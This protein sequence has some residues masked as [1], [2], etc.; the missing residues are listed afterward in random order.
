MMTIPQLEFNPLGKRVVTRAMT[1]R[2]SDS[3]SFKD[4]ALALSVFAPDAPYEQ[5]LKLAFDM[6]DFDGDKAIGRSDLEKL[7]RHL[8]PEG[9]D[10]LLFSPEKGEDNSVKLVPGIAERVLE[11]ADIDGDGL[12]NFEE[13][14]HA[15]AHS[16]IRA[17][18]TIVF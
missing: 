1:K 17:K 4:F 8:L 11:E 12:L 13:F 18:L 14:S 9:V 15:V 3:L 10:D 6:F 5:K 2:N 7:L 16:D